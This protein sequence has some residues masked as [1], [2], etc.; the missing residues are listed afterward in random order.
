MT[1]V[2]WSSLD[3]NNQGDPLSSPM[4]LTYNYLIVD[5]LSYCVSVISLLAMVTE[6]RDNI[7]VI[8]SGEYSSFLQFL[9]P[10]FYNI[11]RQG[12]V[13]FNDAAAT[14]QKI[15]NT[16]LEILNKLP[17]NELLKP[18]VQNLLQLSMYLLEVDNEDNA[19]ICLRIIM[20]LHKNYR[21][22]L[23][24]EV[25]SFLNIVL[26]MYEELPA[27]VDKAFKS[28]PQPSGSTPALASP[29]PATPAAPTSS[30]PL[31]IPGS[32]APRAQGIKPSM[33]SFKVLTE[34]PIIVVLLFQLYPSSTT[35]VAKFIPLIIKTLGISA[36][37]NSAITHHQLY[38]DFIAAQV[39]TLSFLA[40]ILKQYMEQIRPFADVFPKHV[41]QLLQNCPSQSSG[42][43]KELLIATRYI[44][45]S[46]LKLKFIGYLD[47]LL[48]ERVLIGASRTSFETLRFI[49]Y[50]SLA[51]FIHHMRAELTLVQIAKVVTLYSKHL[52]DPTNPFGIQ[53]ISAKLLISIVEYIPR[54]PDPEFKARSIIY[55][56]F[57]SL[58]N[59]FV[60]LKKSIPKILAAAQPASAN[61]D[62]VPA[63]ATAPADA[64]AAAVTDPVKDCRG[65]IK[66]IVCGF[67]NISWALNYS[68]SVRNILLPTG[69]SQQVRAALPPVDESLLYIKLF[70]NMVKCL[71]IFGGPNPA[72]TEEKDILDHF[73]ITLFQLEYRTFQELFTAV[74]PFLYDR[75]AD[76]QTLLVLPQTILATP[77]NQSNTAT[78]LGKAF[79]EIIAPF[80]S[81][82][83]KNLSPSDVPDPV[84]IRLLKHLFSSVQPVNNEIEP[85]IQSILANLI[86][87]TTKLAV[88]S[89]HQHSLQSCNKPDLIK[90]IPILFPGILEV[91]TEL[92]N[93]AYSTEMMHLF[94]ELSLTIP[95]RITNFLPCIPMLVRPLILALQS[96]SSELLSI[97]FK[98]LELIVDN[99]TGD[100]LLNTF[101][102]N[103]TEFLHAIWMHL[104][105][106]PYFFGPHAV[107]V[108][109]K[110]AGKSRSV[111]VFHPTP[112]FKEVRA[113][114][115]ALR[116][117]LPYESSS[118][119]VPL[120]S[121]VEAA[122]SVLNSATT[123]ELSLQSAFSLLRTYM[124]LFLARAGSQTASSSDALYTIIQTN[125]AA[126]HN[127]GVHF[128]TLE[129]PIPT[130]AFNSPMLGASTSALSPTSPPF[131][132]HLHQQKTA[133]DYAD[134]QRLVKL[135]LTGF[136][137]AITVESLKSTAKA[138]LKQL[139]FH[140][141]LQI[142]MRT[143]DTQVVANSEIDPHIFFD[144]LLEYMSQQPGSPIEDLHEILDVIYKAC[145]TLYAI[146]PPS[147]ETRDIC[148]A[149]KRLVQS[150]IH[151]CYRQEAGVK[152]AGCMGI[153]FFITKTT[154]C[155][156]ILSYEPSFLRALIH[157]VDDLSYM[158]YQPLVDY[159]AEVISQMLKACTPSLEIPD[160]MEVDATTMPTPISS[161]H[162]QDTALTPVSNNTSMDIDSTPTT[163]TTIATPAPDLS[164]PSSPMTPAPTIPPSPVTLMTGPTPSTPLAPPP[165]PSAPTTAPLPPMPPHA[166][167]AQLD[168]SQ[169]S[170]LIEVV[171]ILYRALFSQ[172][173]HTRK[174]IQRVLQQVAD[175]THIPIHLLH[176]DARGFFTKNL[177]K[178]LK[179]LSYPAQTGVM[180]ALTFAMSQRTSML[181][182]TP[183]TIKFLNDSLSVS[184]EDPTLPLKANTQKNMTQITALRLAGLEMAAT[185]MACPE[186]TA[187][188]CQD[189]KNRII[190]AFFKAVTT[191]NKEIAA[192]AKRGL[193]LA[194]AQ[195]RLNRD[196]LQLCLK[197]VL[198]NLTDPKNISVPF[199][200][201][202][203]RLL[204]LLSYCFNA[205]LG[206]KLFE[207]LKKF[208][209]THKLTQAA[210]R[211]KEC[212]E[213]RVCAAIIDTFHLLPTAARL[214]EPTLAFTLKLEQQLGREVSSPYRAP[215]IRF[216]AKYPAKC[217]ELFVGGTNWINP[218]YAT[219]FRLI[220]KS[221]G[222]RPIIDELAANPT[223]WLDATATKPEFQH[224]GLC[225]ARAVVK[226]HPAWLSERPAV[227]ERLLEIWR[228][229]DRRAMLNG[230][231][232]ITS[233]LLLKETRILVKCF[234]SACRHTL[235]TDLLMH[236]LYTFTI[237]AAMDFSFLK[238]FYQ[239]ELVERSTIEQKRQIL[240]AFLEYFR[241]P[242]TTPDM[243]MHAIQNIVTPLLNSYFTHLET[244]RAAPP[245][246][247]P[248]ATIDSEIFV[249]LARQALES[250]IPH[251]EMLL[252]E[253]LQLE[254]ILV[255]NMSNELIDLRKD[256]IKFAWNHFKNEDFT[257]RQSAYVLACRFIEAYETPAKIVL[258]V[259]V[260]LLKAFQVEAK[261]LVKQALDILV[262]VLKTRL[263]SDAAR[264]ENSTWIKWTKKIIIEESH[265][266]HQ[267]VH[268][269][270]LI[271]RH[272]ALF[273]PARAQFI[274]HMV[275]L[276]P[277]LGL[278]SNITIENKKLSI[279]ITEL[280]ITWERWRL[281]DPAA[282]TPPNALSQPLSSSSSAIA[283]P[284]PAPAA[285]SESVNVTTPS[286]IQTPVTEPTPMTPM[287]TASGGP[288][289]EYKPP[290]NVIEHISLFLI[291]MMTNLIDAKNQPLV[292]KC[293]ELQRAALTI[294]PE[295]N[296][297]FAVFEKPLHSDQPLII[298]TTLNIL[299]II[300]EH[301]IATFVPS[302][303]GALP[304]LLPSVALDNPRTS[305][306]VCSLFTKMLRAFPIG[307]AITPQEISTFYTSVSTTIEG[308]LSNF[309]K[310]LNLSIVSLVK[311]FKE[312][313]PEFVDP[314]LGHIIRIIQRLT[315]SIV[316]PNEMPSTAPLTPS[317][318]PTNKPPTAPNSTPAAPGTVATPAAP[319]P[320]IAKPPTAPNSTPA[321]PG[322]SATPKHSERDMINALVICFNLVKGKVSK[323]TSEQKRV[324][325]HSLL[326]L[327]ERGTDVELLTEVLTITSFLI[328]NKDH[329]L[330]SK[331][332]VNFILKMARVGSLDN[333]PLVSSYFN[334]IHHVY[335]D[336][337]STRLELSQLESGFMLGLRAHDAKV[338]TSLFDILHKSIGAAPYQRLNYIVGVQQWE[339]LGNTYWIR[340]ALD[341]LLA[342]L[343]MNRTVSLA[344]TVSKIPHALTSMHS[345]MEPTTSPANFTSALVEYDEWIESYTAPICSDVILALRDL[346]FNN[347][348]LCHNMW[349]AMFSSIWAK[350]AKEEHY[351]LSKS[352]TALL[353]K[354]HRKAG[355]AP[356]EANAIV[357]TLLEGIAKCSPPPKIPVDIISYVG[358]TYNT[359][360]TAVRL[361][362]HP[363]LEGNK[364]PEPTEPVWEALGALYSSLNEK[365]LLFGLLRKRFSC[366]ET[367]LGL[368]LEQFYMWQSAQE[369]Y[370]SAMN[371]YSSNGA[372][373]TPKSENLLWEDHWIECAKR[374][375]QWE[376]LLDFARAQNMNELLVESAWKLSAW[377]VMKEGLGK[378]VPLGD[379]AM[380]KILQGYALIIDKKYTEV[381]PNIVNSNQLILKRWTALPER[382]FR[383][384]TQGLIEM[385][386]VVE[387]Q[388][389]VHLLKE[390]AMSTANPQR[391]V[392]VSTI[393][394]VKT[395][396]GIWRERL[397]SKDEDVG[398]WNEL[399]TWRQQVFSL[400]GGGVEH[401]SELVAANTP[402]AVLP[403]P[404][405]KPIVQPET[406]W[407]M[408][409]F[410][411][412]SRQHHIV[413]VCLH[414]LSKMFNLQ[415]EVQDIFLNLK[416]QI[417]CYLQLPTHYDT[418]ISIING[419]N[420][421]YFLPLQK[422]EFFQLKGE[423]LARLGQS[424]DANLN[425]STAIGL[426]DN[427]AKSWINWGHF[428]DAQFAA[429]PRNY[430]NELRAGWAESAINCYIQGIRSDAK[431]GFKLIPRILWLL[432][433]NG[434]GE[435]P[436]QVPQQQSAGA[437]APAVETP[438]PTL[439]Q[440][441]F[442]S[443]EKTWSI[444]PHWL[445]LQFVPT[446]ISGAFMSVQFPGYGFLCW[447]LLSKICYLFPNFTYYH[448]R[449]LVADMRQSNP[450]LTPPP[451]LPNVTTPTLPGPLMMAETLSIGLQPYHAA[452]I[453]EIETM[454]GS[455]LSLTT[456]VP[457][458]HHLVAS[459]NHVLLD[460]IKSPLEDTPASIREDIRTV[461]NHFFVSEASTKYPLHAELIAHSKA[462]FESDFAN[463]LAGVQT[464]LSQII[465]KLIE[466]VQ[467][468]PDDSL[469]LV[470]GPPGSHTSSYFNVN[471]TVHL[472]H[473][474]PRISELRPT[475]L[476]VPAQYRSARDPSADNNVKVD[477][478]GLTAT[479]VKNA[480]GLLVPRVTLYG[481]NGSAYHFLID[482]ED[483]IFRQ[484]KSPP[485]AIERRTQLLSSINSLLLKY[486]ETR[487]RNITLSSYPLSV[488][489]TDSVSMIQS[490][491]GRELTPL[492][493]VW[494]SQVSPNDLFTPLV[495]YRNKLL[496][497]SS[498]TAAPMET[499]STQP[500]TPTI[501]GLTT[502]PSSKEKSHKPTKLQAFRE[503]SKYMSDS[504]MSTYMNRH[505]SSYQEHY[506]FKLNFASQWGLHSILS[507][508]LFSRVGSLSPADIYFSKSSGSV[509]F[510]K[511]A[512]DLCSDTAEFTE[513]GVVP[514][515]L[516]QNIR[517]YL[518]P[519]FIEGGYQSS[520]LATSMC[521]S[522]AKIRSYAKRIVSKR[523]YAELKR[524]KID[525]DT[526]RSSEVLERLT[527]PPAVSNYSAV[528]PQIR[529][530]VSDMEA[531]TGPN[532]EGPISTVDQ[533]I[534]FENASSDL[535]DMI[536]KIKYD[537][538][539]LEE[540]Q[541]AQKEEEAE[542]L[543]KRKAVSARSI[544]RKMMNRSN[545]AT[546]SDRA[547]ANELLGDNLQEV[548]AK[549]SDEQPENIIDLDVMRARIIEVR[550]K[551]AEN[552]DDYEEQEGEEENEELAELRELK[553]RLYKRRE[554]LLSSQDVDTR[555]RKTR[556][557]RFFYQPGETSPLFD[558]A[559]LKLEEINALELKELERQKNVIE[560]A[561]LL[562]EK[563]KDEIASAMDKA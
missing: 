170:L 32:D 519:I 73:A 227:L 475:S 426:Y 288:D 215:L 28:P 335:S 283:A 197:P 346:A 87:T 443:I 493:D 542:A 533:A 562:R 354:D 189:F 222:T 420:L 427:Y 308:I 284:P 254:T 135:M 6:I 274:P 366:D 70:R 65:L 472:E 289:D 278:V 523:V 74:I 548:D 81:E 313:N 320:V 560:Y 477:R 419:T 329:A 127:V 423:F 202:L 69:Q 16:I 203:A 287:V 431:H 485:R 47:Q 365:D 439:A 341:L 352:L 186:F 294:W 252:I 361:L 396:F 296:I 100:F 119:T 440:S 479:M 538:A 380:R 297:K 399:L 14:D 239:T 304:A 238:D 452:L 229:P 212:E 219:T 233:P 305:A 175:I 34:C 208:E 237:R 136:F 495:M 298:G 9:F 350:L 46:D 54:K 501:S 12:Q 121:S 508:I 403:P 167:L 528:K 300:F 77:A 75:A 140:F 241:A 447:Q 99:V 123:D 49:A 17:N 432:Y 178:S 484:Q 540:A 126:D 151:A 362:E 248:T 8:H 489:I 455:F 30:P 137:A 412:I 461:H 273:Y 541:M 91:L 171:E 164:L 421:D 351:K 78:G 211:F 449:R 61:T 90:E 359:Y 242:S 245:P 367:K 422:S 5:L 157:V 450:H 251:E 303:V 348:T 206:E 134:E 269:L 323:L 22:N 401:I 398:V 43:R 526:I 161:P 94:V 230:S 332:K 395:I 264:R 183:D 333:K 532:T 459:L 555:V 7:E 271:V 224:L 512:S 176:D 496:G 356:N 490:L 109:G 105:P 255:K 159:G 152:N 218:Q 521:F 451:T 165:A 476:E 247:V 33:S 42:I 456:M 371:K 190:R 343:P 285:A 310:N 384:H 44:L 24:S 499:N 4:T 318:V 510:G 509:Y 147:E 111:T 92:I 458:I 407:T 544:V 513:N 35:N 184:G 517:A 56:I 515:R 404:P 292:D 110:M 173:A 185:T 545:G 355:A 258:Q 463:V 503:M 169:R 267:L 244:I 146:K 391:P 270:Q 168:E 430:D 15:R 390:V 162:A 220:L 358:E 23:E 416:E 470:P 338:R 448:F 172:Q 210:N 325:Q 290:I 312:E 156:W 314:Y 128:N 106:T 64:G 482:S 372:K 557:S 204:E 89:K 263:P 96:T 145:N 409:K 487:R 330:P 531:M 387:L 504:L 200:Q 1:F 209:E 214:L 511:W 163:N 413:E 51:D 118:L 194:I 261:H 226:S 3:A 434:S 130:P 20:E 116:I 302:N 143:Q 191:R 107:R 405:V 155:K 406:S 457:A 213:V 393:N 272:P 199:L 319:T 223:V 316:A 132:S 460:A 369:V 502:P 328:T 468:R 25:Q 559:R 117:V 180:E 442:S 438:P 518:N 360:Y 141:V 378:L 102:D 280:I 59:K 491:G 195:Q 67:R 527:K 18:H 465:L 480:S 142:S 386:Q 410:A 382:S 177:P 561:K 389:A 97:A 55:R 381:D 377:P 554:F 58:T 122:V 236:M 10:L 41:I 262:P 29:P 36:P 295:A 68:P 553:Y 249:S 546:P 38:V 466:W 344:A 324:F 478:I 193:A 103:K 124:G 543:T 115:E 179:I 150:F 301:Q 198:T 149:F 408:N 492:L 79:S 253:L 276:L 154:E 221:E 353:S 299:N 86:V 454:L 549:Y 232:E 88:E 336:P 539:E 281:K 266:Q 453:N 520:L 57:E 342:I 311:A 537:T 563:N 505:I 315:A 534:A 394:D 112:L 446:L 125:Y 425:F 48:D 225:I 282:S 397:P 331:E 436:Q 85:A 39:K 379:T 228:S 444:I 259:Y 80:L 76:D 158:G 19:T 174:A 417:K 144:A 192:I 235:S 414:S 558:F 467:R 201:G 95:V 373:T 550:R 133:E 516:T 60:S 217:V 187:Y 26:K 321:A 113:D 279:D 231:N 370:L 93:S 52:H 473:I 40:Y 474:C 483:N 375:N 196:L 322:T 400:I 547:L 306:L 428:C 53:T 268:I 347:T 45:S 345:P 415:I 435:V 207:Y 181:A 188:E 376:V 62:A 402:S 481:V 104:K 498:S 556:A 411:H 101:K 469:C 246:A 216:L 529:S 445:W 307:A 71:A 337:T 120:D 243:K 424:A 326:W 462:S 265:S 340:H 11:L 522:E 525:W 437:A 383:A 374:L 82:K 129:A 13:Q 131:T 291:R 72:P 37:P 357:R 514:F 138:Y 349:V 63:A 182:F 83:L 536:N 524:E 327:L 530:I 488:S 31:A 551:I 364:T 84:L 98:T 506:E 139:T 108:L 260:Q 418:G 441:V 497:T 368:L 257:C 317:I 256:L 250:E 66:T 160:V 277:K 21:P 494:A 388:E 535:L 27:T 486:R 433:L 153:Q 240:V 309:D 392:L 464:S 429:E 50:S 552:K 334:L 114:P 2:E 471:S 286:Q 507:Y 500:P 234:L 205:A 385:Q 339:T 275:S 293:S 166:T 148:P 363:L